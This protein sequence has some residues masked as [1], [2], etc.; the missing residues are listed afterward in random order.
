MTQSQNEIDEFIANWPKTDQNCRQAFIELR[1]FLQ[2]QELTTLEFLARPGV[3]YSLR[4]THQEQNNKP[5]FVMVDVIE[6][7]PRWL[8]T[9]FYG[10]MVTDPEELGDYVPGGL[11]GEDGICFDMEDY[12][13]ELTSYL[14]KRITEAHTAAC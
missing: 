4:A 12:S 6:D 2:Q 10:E 7:E 9:C 8:S 1:D 3:S 5:L 13:K 14:K 11:L